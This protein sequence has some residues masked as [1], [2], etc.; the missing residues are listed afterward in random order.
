MLKSPRIEPKPK[1]PA[2]SCHLVPLIGAQ[3]GSTTQG[4]SGHGYSDL[5][6]CGHLTA[7]LVTCKDL[8][9]VLYSPTECPKSPREEIPR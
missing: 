6:L 2:V 3:T 9:A 1:V 7:P 8:P 5:N 4:Q